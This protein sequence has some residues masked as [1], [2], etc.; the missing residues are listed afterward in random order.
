LRETLICIV[1]VAMI[2]T[3]YFTVWRME[4]VFF[5]DPGY[6]SENLNVLRGLPLFRSPDRGRPPDAPPLTAEERQAIRHKYVEDFKASVYWAFA[7]YEQSNWHPLTWLSHMLDVELY[8][9]WE[10]GHHITNLVL[11]SLN[12]LLLFLLFWRLTGRAWRSAA[13]AAMF[14]VHPMHVE[15]VAWVAERKDVLS[16]FLGLTTLLL[17]VAY[18]RRAAIKADW[19]VL[20]AALTFLTWVGVVL[21]FNA[22]QVH[23]NPGELQPS[24]LW[25]YAALFLVTAAYAGVTGRW[26]LLLYFAVFVL[27]AVGL[28]A[29][30]M[31]VTLPLLCLLLDYWPLRRFRRVEAPPLRALVERPSNP[32]RRAKRN[33]RLPIAERVKPAETRA[34]QFPVD[35]VVVAVIE[36]LP[37][38]ALSCISAIITPYAQGHGGSMASTSDLPISFRLQNV[39]QSYAGYIGRMFWPGKMM[40]L[41]L[42]VQDQAGHPYCEP[43]MVALALVVFM[44]LSGVAVAAFIFRRRYVAF[45]WAWYVITLVPV[46]GFIQVGEQAMADRYT[47]IPYIGLFVAI[48]WAI[49]DLLD[50]L[51]QW[52]QPLLLVVGGATTFVLATWICWTN[53]QI[54]TW[55]DVPTHLRHALEVEPENWNMLNNYGV[56]LWKEAQ[57]YE[58]QRSEALAAGDAQKA[59]EADKRVNEFKDAAKE[60]WI[61]G[62]TA[63]PTATDIHSNLGYAY[64]EAA[65][66]AQEVANQLQAIAAQL[67]TTNPAESKRKLE[68]SAQKEKESRG[69]L[70]RAEFHLRKA[71]ELK[72]ISPRPHNNLG[73]VLLRRNQQY[74]SDAHMLEAKANEAEAKFHDA[75]TK[76]KTD[77]A[78]AAKVPQLKADAE[79]RRAE[80][81]AQV[82]RLKAE[83]KLKLEQALAEFEKS[84]QLDPSLLEA[85]L[86]LGEVYT[87]L[88]NYDKAT[89]HYN[90]I[91]DLDTIAVVEKDAI[92]NFSQAHFGLARIAFFQNK[93]DEAIKELYRAIAKNSN[94]MSAIVRLRDE[95][96]LRGNYHDAE[97]VM[98][99]WLSK[100]PARAR[101][102]EVKKLGFQFEQGGKHEAA[103]RAWS[104]AAWIFATSPEPQLRDPKAAFDLARGAVD[105]TKQQDPVA[106]DSL[107]AALAA[108]GQFGNAV[109]AAQA[110][111]TLANNQGN[112]P[113]AELITRRLASYQKTA[114]YISDPKGSDRP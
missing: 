17:Y 13:V 54:Q 113:L 3:A 66:M 12:S 35:Q 65:S 42:L 95:Y 105:A 38:F 46:I 50:H 36:K 53:C 72:D 86:N 31:L 8:N 62:I 20:A 84:V 63:R 104:A 90:R 15:S 98:R 34:R 23:K 111:I 26:N 101:E 19:L 1:L 68:E 64:S 44:S 91:L 32:K 73:R 2:A 9:Q 49:G 88:G 70:D 5:D 37:L 22:I 58:A 71:V 52:R 24:L 109:Q 4:F 33:Q 102:D 82:P 14:A 77:P 40:S 76:G 103:G 89:E 106:L 96:F 59:A 100:L 21:C 57:K 6:V 92:A 29:K 67:E 30:P 99:L 18:A 11:H 74:E 47:Y 7:A 60:S 75:E 93:P 110:A 10:G 79:S 83:A 41:H 16:T 107:A 25:I 27:Y 28:L 94:N 45:G 81:D 80:A 85:R 43:R 39:V 55:R 56:W 48:V 97:Q 112:K 114:P 87:S 51:P 69:F 61:H 78:I 108:A